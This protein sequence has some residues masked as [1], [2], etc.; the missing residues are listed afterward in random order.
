MKVAGVGVNLTRLPAI[1]A[2]PEIVLGNGAVALLVHF[3]VINFFYL[4]F[5]FKHFHTA[6]RNL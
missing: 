3:N 4:V 6:C 5:G 1:P 2:Q